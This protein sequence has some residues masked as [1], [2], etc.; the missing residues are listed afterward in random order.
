MSI[1]QQL[2]LGPSFL[3]FAQQLRLYWISGVAMIVY[4]VRGVLRA[5]RGNQTACVLLPTCITTLV[6]LVYTLQGIRDW[7]AFATWVAG[8]A[9]LALVSPTTAVCPSV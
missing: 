1:W 3:F 5:K 8:D 7:A 4:L 9:T 6:L 2:Q